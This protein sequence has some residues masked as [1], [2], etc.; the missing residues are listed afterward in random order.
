M[1]NKGT[2]TDGTNGT[3]SNAGLD[4][5][6]FKSLMSHCVRS[7]WERAE[8]WRPPLPITLY[9][10]EETRHCSGTERTCKVCVPCTTVRKRD[11]ENR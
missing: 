4:L 6:L 1:T 9:L 10:T 3:N 7:V 11:E 8:S 2:I 5:E